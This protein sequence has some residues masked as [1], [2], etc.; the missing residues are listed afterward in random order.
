MTSHRRTLLIVVLCVFGAVLALIRIWSPTYPPG[1]AGFIANVPVAM[2]FALLVAVGASL[3]LIMQSSDKRAMRYDRDYNQEILDNIQ[4]VI[5]RTDARGCWTSLNPAWER[6]TG[7]SVRESLGWSTTR[8]LH[9][10]CLHEARQIYPRLAS[11]EVS[12]GT[13]HQ[14]FYD[15]DG[16]CRYIQVNV[17]RVQFEDGAFAGTIGNIRDVTA[18]VRQGEALAA[19]EKRFRTLAESAPIGI[20]QADSEGRLTFISKSWARRLGRTVEEM[21]GSGWFE[22]VVN[23]EDFVADPPFT[24][25]EPGI[26]RQREICFRGADGSDIWMET[27]NAAEFDDGGRLLGYYGAAVD[28]TEQKLAKER[29]EE[30]ERRFQALASLAPAGIYRTDHQGL[31]TYVNDAWLK[32]TGMT[33]TEWQGGGWAKALHPKD[34]NRVASA[35]AATVASSHEFREVFRWRKPDGTEVWVD[36]IGRPEFDADGRVIGFIGVNMDITESRNAE[37]A[38]AERDRQL[39]ILTENMTDT[40]VRLRP[41]GTCTYAS[42]SAKELFNVDAS[43]LVGGNLLADFHPEDDARVRSTFA[44]LASGERSRALIA[45]RSGAFGMKPFYRWIEANCATLR[46]PE[47]GHITEIIASLR[48]VAQTKA[49]EAELRSSRREAEDAARAKSD[50]LA[51]MSHEIRTPMNGVIGFTELMLNTELDETQAEYTRMIAESGQTMMRLLNDILDLS[52]IEAGLMTLASEPFE[53]PALVQSVTGFCR[54]LAMKKSLTLDLTI[55]PDVPRWVLGDALR[56][57]Q[58]LLNIIGNAVK[59]TEHGG[60]TIEVTRV[61][62]PEGVAI[63]VTDTGIGISED[64]IDAI[65]EQFTQADPSVARRFGGTGLGLAITAQLVELMDGGIEVSSD[66]GKGS[67]FGILLPLPA[68]REPDHAVAPVF[69]GPVTAHETDKGARRILVAEDVDINQKLIESM[70]RRIGHISTVVGDGASAIAAV[71]QAVSDGQPFDLVLMDIQMPITDGLSATRQLREEGFTP[72]DLPIVALTANAFEEDIALCLAAGMQ[73]H[74]AKPLS[75]DELSRIIIQWTG[76][77]QTCQSSAGLTKPRP[78][79]PRLQVKYN[80]RKQGL[81]ALL[82]EISLDNVEKRWPELAEALHQLAGT[83]A[84]F[85]EAPLGRRAGRIERDLRKA[86]E[87]LRRIEL[88]AESMEEMER[89]A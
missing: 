76:A 32:L 36:T 24:G 10:E 74:L 23:R 85:G 40:V 63:S 20:F 31:C 12:E 75:S 5:F 52:K 11:G 61:E 67:H 18:Q 38:L 83:A 51:N 87:N 65:F 37:L 1:L 34:Q 30:S 62:E 9:P 78:I 19:S 44:D 84:L 26:V 48:N 28:I 68:T 60:V 81:R 55:A 88:V 46:D 56:I 43:I 50:F 3:M 15:R 41:D 82:A 25:F 27:H 13:L 66:E 70:I 71:R 4:D 17:R 58:A 16:D 54:P 14:R 42:P 21:V 53:L 79:S 2:D 7:Y 6:I 73:A 8:L 39:T 89:A 57:R 69:H 35:W 86:S 72:A 33:G 47:T 45:F 77:E 29:L 49:L 59:F 22:H 80:Q 64:R